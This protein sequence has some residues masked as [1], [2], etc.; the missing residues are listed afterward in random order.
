MR[1]R[2]TLAAATVLAAGALLGWLPA[3]GRPRSVE[4]A[5]LSS[6]DLQLRLTGERMAGAARL[7]LG[8][9][10]HGEYGLHAL[11]STTAFN[12]NDIPTTT[13]TVVGGTTVPPG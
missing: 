9:D 7:H 13:T 3:A 8:T 10:V 6:R 2:T 4:R 12:L 11:D 1:T 5:D